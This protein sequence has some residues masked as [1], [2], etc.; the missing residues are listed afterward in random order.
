M[1]GV[2]EECGACERCGRGGG[3]VVLA[4]Y[5]AQLRWNSPRVDIYDVPHFGVPFPLVFFLR[6]A[7]KTKCEK[8]GS[9][10]TMNVGD[11][12]RTATPLV[13]IHALTYTGRYFV[14]SSERGDAEKQNPVTKL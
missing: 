8:H 6:K 13:R 9:I 11:G 14:D 12:C 10:L 1:L 3:G 4:R 7:A 2:S 5:G